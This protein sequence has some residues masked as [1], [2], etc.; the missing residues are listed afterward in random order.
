[1]RCV[2]AV[3]RCERS[4]RVRARGRWGG[5][6]WPTRA[7]DLRT[8][9]TASAN[10]VASSVSGLSSPKVF[11]ILAI[12]PLSPIK[13][14]SS[15]LLSF[16][17]ARKSSSVISLCSN[18]SHNWPASFLYVVLSFFLSP[19]NDTDTRARLA[20]PAV[21]RHQPGPG[22]IKMCSSSAATS[23]KDAGRDVSGSKNKAHA[24]A[25]LSGAGWGVRVHGVR[26]WGSC[27]RSTVV[28]TRARA[29][30][31]KGARIPPAA[32]APK[33]SARL[34]NAAPETPR[35][36]L[37]HAPLSFVG[38][39]A[40]AG[41]CDP[42]RSQ[43]RC[44]R[45]RVVT[46]GRHRHGMGGGRELHPVQSKGGSRAAV[47]PP[48]LPTRR[49][50]RG[51]PDKAQAPRRKHRDAHTATQ[52][53]RCKHAGSR[54]R[55]PGEGGRPVQRSRGMGCSRDIAASKT[56]LAKGGGNALPTICWLRA[57]LRSQSV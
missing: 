7:R 43:A 1:M 6:R 28:R 23:L 57:A 19:F 11:I 33:R 14:P 32:M 53:L 2:A 15:A 40:S 10:F 13:L 47:S 18:S 52:A 38:S 12:G 42:P 45:A 9:G 54:H 55:V 3:E 17:N 4:H 26:A 21:T 30:R 25:H 51:A 31:A 37:F 36:N 50:R 24:Q 20:R 16:L 5:V 8:G 22:T 34:R 46:S 39:L 29:T 35:N 27:G 56:A 41:R 44:A 48:F 49:T